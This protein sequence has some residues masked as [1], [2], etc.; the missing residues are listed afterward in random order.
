MAD[1]TAALRGA[2]APQQLSLNPEE[3]DR[4]LCNTMGARRQ[5][6]GAVRP[7]DAAQVQQLVGIARQYAVAL[8][9]I[10]TG[11]NWGYGS[12][13]PAV[14]G[15]LL[16]DLSSLNRIVHFDPELATV[17]LEPGVTQGMLFEFLAQQ[18]ERFL[19]PTTG[20]GPHC[21][22]VGNALERGYGITP[23]ADHFAAVQSVEAVLGT[24]ELYQG[25]LDGLGANTVERCFKW[26][27]GPYVDGLFG[28]FGAGIVTRMTFQLAPVPAKMQAFYFWLDA[29]S[30]LDGAVT[31]VRELQHRLPGIVGSVNLMNARRLLSMM[32]AYPRDQV[33]PGA[34]MPDALVADLA[35]ENRVSAWMGFGA[36]YGEAPV[37]AGARRVV[38]QRLK[39][40][41]DRSLFV[42]PATVARVRP[43]AER[44]PFAWGRKL[45]DLAGTLDQSLRLVAGE[46]SDI[47]L[48]LA[49]WRLGGDRPGGAT[50]SPAEDGTGLL[51]YA[52]LVPMQPAAVAAYRGMVERVCTAHGIEPLVTFTSLSPRCFDSTVPILFDPEEPGARERAHACFDALFAEGKALG[53]V[54]YRLNVEAQRSAIDYD[55]TYWRLVGR[56]KQALDPDNLIAP[57]RYAPTDLPARAGQ[58]DT[59]D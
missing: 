9:P 33:P 23:V 3:Y 43:W 4:Y 59:Q 8:Y 56:I 5:V 40:V 19:V 54:P 55:S 25:P 11:N 6:L 2:F 16:V 29:D 39:G 24:G 41:A 27:L 35:R 32:V 48:P 17:T 26:G 51:W 47:A 50:L 28:Q 49:Y 57:G 36:L 44:L 30:G 15:C 58:P 1:L 13:L 45:A 38:R 42:S 37:V 14:D 46:P 31:A 53:F 52:P 7:A 18:P 22:L 34:V 10:S 21:S 20:A 12:A